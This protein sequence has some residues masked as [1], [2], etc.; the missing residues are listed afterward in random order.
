[1]KSCQNDVAE[2]EARCRLSTKMDVALISVER[3]VAELKGADPP[4][5]S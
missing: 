4:A 2:Q 1:M 3:C 5:L